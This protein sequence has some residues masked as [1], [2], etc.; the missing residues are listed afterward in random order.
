MHFTS[1]TAANETQVIKTSHLILDGGCGIAEFGRVI[2]IIA[3]HHCD[4]S[5]IRDV[6]KGNHLSTNE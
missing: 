2:L 3:S 4:Q 5:A 6:T 1:S